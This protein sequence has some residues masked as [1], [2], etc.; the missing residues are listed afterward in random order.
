MRRWESTQLR[1]RE[2]RKGRS[3]KREIWSDF[4]CDYMHSMKTDQST[5]VLNKVPKLHLCGF[6]KEK[7]NVYILKLLEK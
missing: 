4:I 2:R 1:V 6:F 3:I 5:F 7:I